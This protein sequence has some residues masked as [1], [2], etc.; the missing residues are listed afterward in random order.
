MITEGSYPFYTGGVAV[1]CD[2]L[3]TDLPRVRFSVVGLVGSPEVALQYKIPDNVVATWR[4]PLW[5]IREVLEVRDRLTLRDIRA[6]RRRTTESIVRAEFVPSLEEF[7]GELYADAPDLGRFARAIHRMY[8]FF[9]AYDFDTA[10]RSRS[11]WASFAALARDRFAAA[12]SACGYADARFSLA[13]LTE[14]LTWLSRWLIPIAVELPR[15]DVVHAVS[16]GLSSMPAVASK[17]E[18][19]TPF[20]LTEHGVYLRERYLLEGSTSS[21]FFLKFLGLRF[22]RRITELS[23]VLADQISPGSKYNQRWERRGG[24]R[25]EQ[26]KTIYNGVDPASFSPAGDVREGPPTVVWVGRIT[27]IKDLVT[28]LRAASLVKRSR[29]DVRFKLYGAAPKGDEDYFERC[30]SLRTELGI[31]DTVEFAGF[32]PSAEA[33]FNEADVVVLSSIS[34]GFPYSVVEAMLCAKPIVAT[35]VGG[36]PEAIEGCGIAVEPR[37]PSA[38][39]SALLELAG[40]PARSRR[41]GQA[42]RAKASREFNLAQCSAAYEDAY[43]RLAARTGSAT[44]LDAVSAARVEALPEFSLPAVA[45]AIAQPATQWDGAG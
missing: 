40:D 24:A 10:L 1:W 33:A 30:V 37:N 36:V 45:I 23:Y 32:A 25:A 26:L 31:A 44:A 28:L 20:L 39:A 15:V 34:E 18:H 12:A 13:D 27:P 11:C 7:I 21:S 41:L 14:G 2:R 35:A 42:A 43:R 29:P 38:M 5:G 6:R 4:V 9:T 8:R 22:A 17:L 3:I 16:A 19:G